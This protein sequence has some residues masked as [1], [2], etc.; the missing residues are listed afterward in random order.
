M[1]RRRKQK[2]GNAIT[3]LT[4][5]VS[6]ILRAINSNGLW[7]SSTTKLNKT[8]NKQNTLTKNKNKNIMT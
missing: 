1:G 5:D 3:T 7:K 6:H 2:E 8:G 4:T